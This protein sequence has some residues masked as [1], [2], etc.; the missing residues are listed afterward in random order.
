MKVDIGSSPVGGAHPHSSV[1]ALFARLSSLLHRF[2]PQND[3]PDG[4]QQPSTPLRLNPHAL[5]ARLS[6]LLPQSRLSTNE[7]AEPHPTTPF[8]PRPDAFISQLS[9]FFHSQWQP[10]TNEMVE[11]PQHTSS[12]RVVEVAAVR[13][14][15][16]LV[17]ARGPNFMKA[18][19]AYEQTQSHGQAQA[20]SSHNQPAD[21]S[22][23][24][25]PPTPDASHATAGTAAAH[26]LLSQ[27]VR[28]VLFLCCVTPSHAS[29]HEYNERCSICAT[30]SSSLLAI[31]H[32]YLLFYAFQDIINL[33]PS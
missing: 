27:W 20:S 26:S 23:F 16:S 30:N 4:L 25:T 15:Q 31:L 7:E 3:A 5:L 2:R 10:R 22:I 17:V 11:L 6:S 33:V 24:V 13:D 14:K 9:S 8:S 12:P 19:R 28:V 32:L 1:N 21:A 18:K 29:G